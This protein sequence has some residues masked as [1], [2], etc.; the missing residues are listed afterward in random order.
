MKLNYLEKPDQPWFKKIPKSNEFP[1][2]WITIVDMEVTLSDG[3]IL[4]VAK[5]A[6]FD[7]AMVWD[8]SRSVPGVFRTPGNPLIKL[9][10]FTFNSKCHFFKV[11]F[12]I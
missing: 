1:R 2:H 8:L 4:K 11:S 7:G 12:F 10:C 5:G 9:F 6:I 3:Y